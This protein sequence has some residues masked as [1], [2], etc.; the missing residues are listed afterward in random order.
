MRLQLIICHKKSAP[1]FALFH[2]T[3]ANMQQVLPVQTGLYRYDESIVQDINDKNLNG[4][5]QNL[6]E[7][8]VVR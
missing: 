4:S 1:F 3:R 8:N 5:L 6:T 2:K 7:V